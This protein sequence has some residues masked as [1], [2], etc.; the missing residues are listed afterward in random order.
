VLSGDWGVVE[1]LRGEGLKKRRVE[2]R[3]G[4]GEEVK[5]WRLEE[6]RVR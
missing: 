1:R 4:S 5:G 3:L 6:W 2:W